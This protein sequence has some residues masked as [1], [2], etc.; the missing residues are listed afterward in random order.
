[1]HPMVSF[2]FGCVAT[3]V[4]VAFGA[5]YAGLKTLGVLFAIGVAAAGVQ[6]LFFLVWYL[7]FTRKKEREAKPTSFDLD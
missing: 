2:I 7:L 4:I 5:Y 3:G 6:A 1:M